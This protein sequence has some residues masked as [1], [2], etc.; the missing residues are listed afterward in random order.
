MINLRNA[1][2]AMNALL[3][4]LCIGFFLGHVLPQ[5]LMFWSSS[6]LR[7]MAPNINFIYIF[8]GTKIGHE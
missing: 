4:L 2:I 5:G 8:S 6:A 3:I 7:L 1:A